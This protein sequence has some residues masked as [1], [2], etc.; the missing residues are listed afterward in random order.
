MSLSLWWG[1]RGFSLLL[2][3]QQGHGHTTAAPGMWEGRKSLLHG[4]EMAWCCAPTAFWMHAPWLCRG[5]GRL[6]S[7]SHP[8]AAGPQGWLLEAG[9]LPCQRW[10]QLQREPLRKIYVHL[11]SPLSPE[12]N[13]ATVLPHLRGTHAV[14]PSPPAVGCSGPSSPAIHLPGSASGDPSTPGLCSLG[15]CLA[16]SPG[17]M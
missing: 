11:S 1:H 16:A 17:P 5:N 3:A 2:E 8:Q 12:T 15:H 10:E 6:G 13:Y 7:S 14:L 4:K 9:V